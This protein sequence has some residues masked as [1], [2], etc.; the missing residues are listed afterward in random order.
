MNAR[1]LA[2]IIMVIG[3]LCLA[4]TSRSKLTPEHGGDNVF[5]GAA[6]NDFLSEEMAI[7][8]FNND[9]YDDIVTTALWDN[10]ECDG[11]H[12]VTWTKSQV[13]NRHWSTFRAYRGVDTVRVCRFPDTIP[14][15]QHWA[16]WVCAGWDSVAGSSI[17]CDSCSTK[18]SGDEGAAYVF[19]GGDWSG[20]AHDIDLSAGGADVVI[21]G[22]NPGGRLYNA[23]AC[24]DMNGD[25][26]TEL[27]LGAPG[28]GNAGEVYVLRGSSAWP[29]TINLA[30]PGDFSDWVLYYFIGRDAGDDF[31]QGLAMGDLNNDGLSELVALAPASDSNTGEAYIFYPDGGIPEYPDTVNLHT[32][33]NTDI[34]DFGQVIYGASAGGTLGVA[35][36]TETHP[37]HHG[38]GKHTGHYEPVA[39]TI[40]NFD[41]SAPND[42]VIG[43]GAYSSYSGKAYVIFGGSKL[44]P[45]NTISLVN[46][47]GSSLSAMDIK[48]NGTDHTAFGAGVEFVDADGDGKDDLL[49]GAPYTSYAGKD[50]VGEVFMINGDTQFNLTSVGSRVR[51]ITNAAHTDM[52]IF[53]RAADDQLG[54]HFAGKQD[55]DGDGK[56]DIGIAG[57]SE[58]TLLFGQSAA[59]PDTL[60]LGSAPD[61]NPSI[62]IL[63]FLPEQYASSSTIR[64]ANLDANSTHD[65]VFGGYDS[66]GYSPGD[67]TGETGTQHAGQMWVM[68]GRDLWKTGTVS[69]NTTWSGIQFVQGDITVQSGKTLTI[70]AGSQ[71]YIMRKDAS[72]GGADHDK[73]E[74]NVEGTLVADGTAAN[75]IVFQSW[76][77]TTPT[78][79]DWVGFYFDNTSG[80]GTFDHCHIKNAEYG[81]ES[82]VPLT[83]TNSVIDTCAY[84]GVL[85][86]N[87]TL[88]RA[89]AVSNGSFG[90]YVAAGATTIRDC[91][92][93]TNSTSVHLQGGSLTM[94]NSS[95]G[96]ATTGLYI[97]GNHTV[98]IDSFCY[99]NQMTTGINCYGTSTSPNIKATG[100]ENISDVAINCDNSSPTIDTDAFYLSYVSVYCSNSSSP[101]IKNSQINVDYDGVVVESGCNPV[102]GT[103]G[104]SADNNIANSLHH[105][106]GKYIRNYSSNTIAAVNDCWNVNTGSCAPASSKFYG[107]VDRSSPVC[108]SFDPG[109][110]YNAPSPKAY[111]TRITNVAPN[112]FNPETTIHYEL[113]KQGPVDIKIYDVTGRL[114]RELVRGSQVVGTHDVRWDGTDR[115]GS[116]TASGVYFVRMIANNQ[117]FTRKMVLLK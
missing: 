11:W 38:R 79:D 61:T 106:S 2:L 94:H 73:I 64:L 25:G 23:M 115:R 90:V 7:G 21:L 101:V 40:G 97:N 72:A 85:A 57:K 32:M 71:I 59:W 112:P 15:S 110:V 51:D 33:N 113:A 26:K 16:R 66:P 20:K 91:T 99:F 93:G 17:S 98:E 3:A 35:F 9:S 39:V 60:A 87:T 95:I 30:D 88:V 37:P 48:I 76:D 63:T 52:K 103:S 56:K 45:G 68:K 14:N 70:S 108:C 81:I 19:F 47:P 109:F 96:D 18:E 89:T 111:V 58:M 77:L 42:L 114:V 43:A 6:Q 1:R 116:P 75:P 4:I 29:D 13:C 105:T 74:F 5:Y 84:A 36:M 83:V 78:D 107:S 31:G 55:F 80:G 41:G 50:S 34:N 49:L 46:A 53:G 12:T 28:A 102:V 10:L 65:L 27:A 22:R 92:I 117:T 62:R 104:G 8:N 24:G 100:F 86:R 44:V 54:G 67:P 69:A 82:Y